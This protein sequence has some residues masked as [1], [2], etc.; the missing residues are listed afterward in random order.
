MRQIAK[1]L[2]PATNRES[3]TVHSSQFTLQTSH[4]NFTETTFETPA[5]CI[6]TP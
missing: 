2:H 4:S 6:V 5:S 1:G 3:V